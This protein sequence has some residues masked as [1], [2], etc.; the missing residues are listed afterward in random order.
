MLNTNQ[1]RCAG[2]LISKNVRMGMNKD[3]KKNWM[4]CDLKLQ[5]S[6]T[7]TIT[8]SMFSN[9]FTSTGAK[10]K[11]YTALET[12]RD[13]YKSLDSTVT[14]KRV[15]PDAQAEKDEA[16]TVATLEE[17]TF[18]YANKGITIGMNRYVR[19]GEIQENFRLSVN[20][21]NSAKDTDA[22]E[23]YLEGTLIG[24]V[25]KKPFRFEEPNG[26]EYVKFELTV[27]T[28]QSAW[29]DRDESV[30]VDKFELVMR[31]ENFDEG[32]FEGAMEFVEEEF[33]ENMIVN[34]SIEPT[35]KVVASQEPVEDTGSKRGFGKKVEFKPTTRTIREIRVLGGYP[36]DEDEYEEDKAFDFELYSKAVEEFER[37]LEEMKAD[38][39]QTFQV[40]RG[41]GNKSSNKETKLPF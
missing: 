39:G 12:I 13:T 32:E 6:E 14:N 20:F 9:E 10:S 5:I 11:S 33:D 28:Y 38:Q 8:L 19:D 40:Q 31:A 21:V 41:F 15:N 29:G 4:M 36:L 34:V 27:P 35:V 7:Q 37:K 24:V 30:V 26:E 3:T 16:T 22:K 1:L 17:T 23:P 25:T 18:V 2:Y